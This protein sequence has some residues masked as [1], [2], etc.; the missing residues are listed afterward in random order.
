[1]AEKS[2]VLLNWDSVSPQW[3]QMVKFNVVYI[4]SIIDS[5]GCWILD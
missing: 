3:G 2:N 1:M 5:A 4:D